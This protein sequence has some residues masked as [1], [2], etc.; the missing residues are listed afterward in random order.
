MLAATAIPWHNLRRILLPTH[1]VASI[2]SHLFILYRD[3]QATLHLAMRPAS[4]ILLRQLQNR[5]ETP[6]Q[7]RVVSNLLFLVKALMSPITASRSSHKVVL[8]RQ[9]SLHTSLVPQ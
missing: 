4:L 1:L 8:P 6:N 2:A 5:M 9:L 7:D 3:H